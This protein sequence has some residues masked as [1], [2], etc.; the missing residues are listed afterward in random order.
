[1]NNS[2]PTLRKAYKLLKKITKKMGKKDLYFSAQIGV[3]SSKDERIPTYAAMIA[4]PAENLEPIYFASLDKEEFIGKI[5]NFL[6]NKVSEKQ[7]SVAFHEA[8]VKANELS[9]EYHKEQIEKITNSNDEPK[10]MSEEELLQK[11]V[12]QEDI[13]KQ[14]KENGK[15]E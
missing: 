7:L 13:D 14:I 9:T 6:N 1:M 10:G 11:G 4:S 5:Q 15:E 8:Q 12:K 2:N 3:D